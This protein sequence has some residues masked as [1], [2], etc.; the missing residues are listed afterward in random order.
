MFKDFSRAVRE[1]CARASTLCSKFSYL[2]G[3]QKERDLALIDAAR[4]GKVNKVRL[5]LDVGAN[6]R[7]DQ[8][9][10][11]RGAVRAAWQIYADSYQATEPSAELLKEYGLKICDV[12]L[13]HPKLAAYKTILGLLS[14]D[15]TGQRPSIQAL[16]NREH[17][18]LEVFAHYMT[19]SRE[20]FVVTT[21]PKIKI[22]VPAVSKSLPQREP[23][24]QRDDRRLMR[25]RYS[26][27]LLELEI[28][29]P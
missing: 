10:A 3:S 23:Q 24:P 12:N 18:C 21:V 6:R 29:T 17:K 8:E 14:H 22:N 20:A 4:A 26:E 15:I 9:G 13:A 2:I 25:Y 19:P 1:A 16:V 27:E 5:L 11:Y 7:V 28:S